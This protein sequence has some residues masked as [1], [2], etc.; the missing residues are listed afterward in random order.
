M[1]LQKRD[2]MGYAIAPSLIILLILL[3]SAAIV[4]CGYAVHRLMGLSEPDNAY[5]PRSVE[6]EDY[7][8]E[9]RSRNIEALMSEGRRAFRARESR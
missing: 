8:R 5:K 2:N 7:M 6:Q 1:S 4:T 3:A 9:V